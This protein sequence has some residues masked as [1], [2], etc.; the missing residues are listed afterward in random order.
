MRI[1][2]RFF[3]VMFGASLERFDLPNFRVL[4]ACFKRVAM[5]CE[6]QCAELD[7]FSQFAV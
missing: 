2:M 4:A 6:F 7:R 1:F 3:C 5:P